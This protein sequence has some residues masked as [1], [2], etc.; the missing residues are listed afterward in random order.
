MDKLESIFE[1][2][3][4]LNKKIGL[5]LEGLSEEEKQA[6]IL[7]YARA[8][9]QE[10]AELT[11]SVPWKWWARY[12]KFD[13]QN[14]NIELI[15]LLHFLVSAF[16]VMGL[17]ADDVYRIYSQK[18]QINITRQDKGYTEKENSDCRHIQ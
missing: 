16:Q 6:W 4:S 3:A 12:Q 8:L 1:L 13:P 5:K 15:D 7:N 9:S 10:V 18:C 14:I 17:S 11:D 2:Q